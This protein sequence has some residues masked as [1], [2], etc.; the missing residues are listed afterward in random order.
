M[1]DNTMKRL[2]SFCSAI[3]LFL[4]LQACSSEPA[5]QFENP[6]PLTSP[7]L[8]GFP[9]AVQGEYHN[10][11]DSATLLVTA[12]TVIRKV[13]FQV[14]ASLQELEKD[15]VAYRL[16]NNTFYSP[17]SPEGLPVLRSTPDSL[18]LLAT[19]AD[20][21]FVQDATHR[22]RKWK[23]AYFL[24]QQLAPNR[25]KVFCLKPT[26]RKEIQL[27]YLNDSID[28]AKLQE[29]LPLRRQEKEIYL[30]NPSQKLLR[31]FLRQGG[32]RDRETFT[33]V[34]ER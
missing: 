2:L 24:N 11:Q 30:A 19:L 8:A 1:E 31:K 34:M 13:R 33:R 17:D 12:T 16:E 25:W 23:G 10:P 32:F 29:I 6:Q 22:L 7:E 21:L 20:T 15:S 14:P 18:L 3:F 28:L 5:V 9:K 4:G 26:G 27:M